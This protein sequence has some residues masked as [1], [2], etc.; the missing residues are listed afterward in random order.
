MSNLNYSELILQQQTE[1]PELDE[2]LLK[3]KQTA[4]RFTFEEAEVLVNFWESGQEMRL[5]EDSRFQPVKFSSLH[6]RLREHKVANDQLYE[7]LVDEVWD[8][9][10]LEIYLQKLDDATSSKTFHLFNPADERFIL[11]KDGT[12]SSK[13]V[14]NDAVSHSELTTEQKQLLVEVLSD[15]A[16]T[17]R[18]WTTNELISELDRIHKFNSVLPASLE[19]W[20][21][22]HPDWARVGFDRW[23]PRVFIPQP[24]QP[25]RYAVNPVIATGT[26]FSP[27]LPIEFEPIDPEPPTEISTGNNTNDESENVIPLQAIWKVA[28]RTWH[29]N[30]GVLSVPKAARIMYP[31]IR[32][33][34]SIMTIKGLWFEDA[35]DLLIWL[36]RSQHKLFGQD[37]HEKL[38]FLEAGTILHISWSQAGLNFVQVGEDVSIREEETRLVDLSGLAEL[39]STQLESYR[40]GLRRL[41]EQT[42]QT[43]TNLYQELCSRQQHK[44]NKNSL[45]SILSASPEFR[46][47][48]KSNQ[49]LLNI[50][51]E[52]ATATKAIRQLV[53]I[54]HNNQQN[55]NSTLSTLI[56]ANRK[57]LALLRK[58]L[59]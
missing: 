41:L 20:L 3:R 53:M 29:I 4:N 12:L 16:T 58:E 47:D 32:K 13:L 38:D 52:N 50:E 45:R 28:L 31:H 17:N 56:E 55:T 57:K 44:I 10:G 18:L 35:S 14:L 48:Q 8:G 46:F 21:V 2:W 15:L 5:R 26:R 37:L 25:R 59:L 39:R 42:P 7:D 40:V 54:T 23:I 19:R 30:E 51:V 33:L 34:N 24:V 1:L 27:T 22:S 6:W 43:F 9:E 11:T 36:D 49:W